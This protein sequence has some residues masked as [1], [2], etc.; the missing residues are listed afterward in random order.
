M[1]SLF[2]HAP[3]AIAVLRG[4][5]HVFELTNG[6]YVELVGGRDVVGKPIREALPELAGQG[7]YELLDSV[8][9]SGEPYIGQSMHV[10]LNRGPRGD[11]EDMLLRLGLPACLQRRGRV[12]SIVV[13][14]HDVTAL[15]IAKHEAETANRLKDE[16]LATLSHELRTPLN[17]ILG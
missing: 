2:T 5:D 4:P 14:A 17:A 15:A 10:R 9:L 1:V 8:R 6:H 7:I 11:A 13:V 16:F 12:D 3:V